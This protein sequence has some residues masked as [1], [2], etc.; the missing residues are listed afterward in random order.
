MVAARFVGLGTV[1]R[2]GEL[3]ALRWSDMRMLD[4]VVQVR[5]AF[6]D[7]RFTTPKSRSSRRLIELG[8]RMR[9][10]L[11]QRWPETTFRATRSAARGV[12]FLCGWGGSRP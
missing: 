5:E 9:E 2:R 8:P 10:R 3:L 11:A 12:H 4:G 7:R 6:V 1:M